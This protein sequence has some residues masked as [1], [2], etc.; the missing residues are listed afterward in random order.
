MSTARDVLRIFIIPGA[1]RLVGRR[2]IV[3]AARFVTNVVRRDE[4]N[5]LRENGERLL[6]RV[7]CENAPRDMTVLDVGANVGDWTAAFFDAAR[8]AGRADFA[9]HAFEPCAATFTMLERRLAALPLRAQALAHAS[10]M[11]EQPEEATLH[12]LGDGIGINSV[13]RADGYAWAR[14]E[15]V[16]LDSLDAFAARHGMAHLTLVKSDT[17]GHDLHVLRGARG[18][19]AKRAI[20]VFQFEYNWRWIMARSYL[21]DV[22]ALAGSAYRLGKLTRTG[23]EWYPSWDPELESFREANYVLSLDECVDWRLSRA[24][25]GHDARTARQMGWASI[26]N[27]ELLALASERFD[28]FVTVDRNLRHQQNIR[29]LPIAIIV[30]HAKTNRLADLLP[31]V[32]NLLAAIRSAKPGVVAL[33]SS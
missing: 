24:L 6:M 14:T 28:V 15:T 18:L 3:R 21:R 22:F 7:V 30:L 27:G 17:E 16:A 31:L 12:V 9:L 32:S 33:V 11:S 2:N 13:H 20:S 25:V 5:D 19:M 23:V 29:A 8:A 26:K 10:G 4:P 1:E